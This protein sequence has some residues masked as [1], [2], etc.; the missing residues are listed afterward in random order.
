[1]AVEKRINYRGGGAYQG[2]SGA[3]G[4]AEAS[5][6]SSGTGGSSGNLGGGG[7]GQDSKYRQY[8]PPTRPTYT[9]ANINSKPV[10][11]ADYRRS[12][13]QFIDNLN[14]NNAS[15][16]EPSFRRRTYKPVTLNTVGARNQRSANPLANLLGFMTGI[17]FGLFN[18]GKSGLTS[19]TNKFNNLQGDFREKYTGYRT[20]EEY[21]NARQ[22]R[23]NLNR[24]NT[25]QNTLDTKYADGDYSMTDLDER[26]A[27]LQEGLGITPNTAAQILDFSNQPE[28]SYEG[29]K[30]LAQP[31]VILG[32]LAQPN[33]GSFGI[34]PERKPVPQYFENVPYKEPDFYS[35]ATADALTTPTMGQYGLNL[36]QLNTLKNSGYSNSQIEEAVDK[37][38]AEELV[39]DIEGP[40]VG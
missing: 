21:D 12:R 20:Q 36:M 33:V 13:N 6:K 19:L 31:D 8:S 35:D 2:G 32:S 25:I 37:G 30:S 23:I 15:R 34:I 3:P 11:G 1:M 22:Q 16:F 17:P 5:S 39:R 10:T 18:Q 26:L 28:L 29:I 24:I 14:R 27:S 7:G 4:S 38:Y 40:I 9:S